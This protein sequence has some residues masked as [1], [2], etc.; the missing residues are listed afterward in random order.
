[1]S[2]NPFSNHRHSSVSGHRPSYARSSSSSHGGGFW[3]RPHNAGSSSSYYRRRPRDGYISRLVEKFRHLLRELW[4]YIRRN[5]LKVLMLV[6]PLVSGGALAAVA[7]QFGVKVPD[8]LAGG[9]GG[10][11]MGG[12]GREFG[13]KESG[14]Y[15]SSGYGREGSHSGRSNS[16]GGFGGGETLSTMM[17]IA[18]AFV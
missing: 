18:K 12:F 3:S 1:M 10:G 11:G 17:N 9:G 16:E 7:R 4:Y 2:W 13:G 15:G 6:V 14:Y 8:I 5:P